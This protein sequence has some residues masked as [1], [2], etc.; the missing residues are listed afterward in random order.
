MRRISDF[1][2]SRLILIVEIDNDF[3]SNVYDCV[4][5]FLSIIFYS[6]VTIVIW[7]CTIYKIFQYVSNT[8][9]PNVK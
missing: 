4:N 3:R 5:L 8:G 1:L 6:F 9:C 2:L 7:N